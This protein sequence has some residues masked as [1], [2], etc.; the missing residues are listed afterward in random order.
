MS[1]DSETQKKDNFKQKIKN[2]EKKQIKK[3]CFGAE[4]LFN[5]DASC[6]GIFIRKLTRH[7]LDKYSSPGDKD[8]SKM[9]SATIP[10]S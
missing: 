2:I 7:K 5:R 9:I 3:K 1:I 6:Q 8:A 10:I 4:K